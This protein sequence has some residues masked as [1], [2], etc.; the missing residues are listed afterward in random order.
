MA[1]QISNDFSFSVLQHCSKIKLEVGML[2]SFLLSQFS[3]FFAT[4]QL[5]RRKANFKIPSVIKKNFKVNICFLYT[6]FHSRFFLLQICI[7]IVSNNIHFAHPFLCDFIQQNLRYYNSTTFRQK[8][9]CS[10]LQQ[11]MPAQI[12]SMSSLSVNI[13]RLKFYKIPYYRS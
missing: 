1:S 6:H 7:F 2:T 13:L 11:T 8:C 5:Y 9:I 3:L 4:A 10:T 12:T